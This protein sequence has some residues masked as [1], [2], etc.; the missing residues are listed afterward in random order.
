MSGERYQYFQHET[1]KYL[2]ENPCCDA[3]LTVKI[4]L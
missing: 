4:C 3:F 2:S 1:T